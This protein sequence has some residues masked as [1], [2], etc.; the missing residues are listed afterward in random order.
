MLIL[1]L[2][3]NLFRTSV[4]ITLYTIAI[5][6][7]MQEVAYFADFKPESLSQTFSLFWTIPFP[8]VIVMIFTHYWKF[9][10][11]AAL[12]AS[13]SNIGFLYQ[14]VCGGL[15][16]AIDYAVANGDYV[17]ISGETGAVIGRGNDTFEQEG[18]FFVAAFILLLLCMP[19]MLF[20]S[21]ILIVFDIIKIVKIII[22]GCTDGWI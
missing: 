19:L 9:I 4:R 18:Y 6:F 15:P 16:A 2:I 1:R 5:L 20:L 10:N 11:T 7:L 3:W 21:P 13:L 14:T 22:T 8:G 12:F 17:I